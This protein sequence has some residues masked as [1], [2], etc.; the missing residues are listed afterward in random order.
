[1]AHQSGDNRNSFIDR[2]GRIAARVV[3]LLLVLALPF[4]TIALVN[5][6]NSSSNIHPWFPDGTSEREDYLLYDEIF[7]PEDYWILSSE[8]AANLDLM[9]QIAERIRKTN[10]LQE[11]P[12]LRRIRSSS[13]V[14]RSLS[15]PQKDSAR[16]L[17]KGVFFDREGRREIVLAEASEHGF[18]NRQL[19]YEKIFEPL[20]DHPDFESSLHIMG[21]GYVGVMADRE[22]QKTFRFV[23][24][25]TFVVSSVLAFLVLGNLRFAAISI[26]TSGI[27]AIGTIALVYYSGHSLSHLLIVIPSLAQLLALSN[28]V[29]LIHYYSDATEN[30]STTT[31][32]WVQ[33]LREGIRPTVAASLTTVIGFLTLLSSS[34]PVVRTF[35]IFGSFSV[36]LTML[37]VL[38]I[39]PTGLILLKPTRPASDWIDT[40]LIPGL[41]GWVGRRHHL[42]AITLLTVFAVSFFG[43]NHLKTEIRTE[44]FFPDESVLQQNID[45]FDR[46]FGSL[47][48]SQLIGKFDENIPLSE[49]INAVSM[50]E[51]SFQ[52]QHPEFKVFSPLLMMGEIHASLSQGHPFETALREAQVLQTHGDSNYWLSTIYHE[53]ID[54]MS[55]SPIDRTIRDQFTE[56][57]EQ[58]PQGSWFVTGTY[59]LFGNAQEILVSELLR[60]FA[61]AFLLITPCIILYL[62]NLKLGLVATLGNVFPIAVFF[63]YLGLFGVSIDIATMVIASIAFGIAVDDTIHFLNSFTNKAIRSSG[64]VSEIVSLAYRK[65]GAAILKTTIIISGGMLAF[66]LSDFGPSRRFALFTSLVLVLAAIGDLVLL[67]ALFR[68]A[69]SRFL[70]K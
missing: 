1:M 60:T 20:L 4:L 6:E 32:A 59:R 28:S 13:D 70:K 11:T 40:R 48:A 18:R 10:D 57:Q 8:K 56:I 47:Q 25:I 46:E 15:D 27:A 66:M 21:P 37:C 36:L 33:A 63:G 16:E 43:F 69:F 53:P 65:S 50:L 2:R 67:P 9:D 62:R 23:T 22:T 19:V 64:S 51:T 30:P 61:Y 68:G 42:F 52:N 45:W 55:D 39:V 44:T 41:D 58:F 35:S 24:P 31:P 3:L 5:T 17:L 38:T 7:G 54:D 14:L 12:L 29:H 34:L 49:Q 26:F